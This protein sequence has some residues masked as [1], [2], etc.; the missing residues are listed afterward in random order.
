MKRIEVERL[1]NEKLRE[2]IGKHMDETH[3]QLG[4]CEDECFEE[5]ARAFAKWALEE[6]AKQITTDAIG[7]YSEG[8]RAAAF[9]V[10]ALA[11][12]IGG[13]DVPK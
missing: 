3:A 8:R 11:A 7:P 2:I 9:G 6:A 12:Q 13:D 1:P 4:R 10:R 5:V